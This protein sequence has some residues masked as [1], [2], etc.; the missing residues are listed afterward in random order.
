MEAFIVGLVFLVVM[1]A[2]YAISWLITV[3][4]VKLIAACF[5]LTATTKVATGIW[6]IECAVKWLFYKP[7]DREE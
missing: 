6:L 2:G 4:L 7:K 3:V 5:G 1:V